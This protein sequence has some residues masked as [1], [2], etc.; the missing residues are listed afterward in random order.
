MRLTPCN[1][2]ARASARF[3][4]RDTVVQRIRSR[5]VVRTL[6]RRE[7]RA[8]LARNAAAGICRHGVGGL[9]LLALLATVHPEFHA[10][11]LLDRDALAAGEGWRLWTSHLAHFS[12]EHLLVD[13]LIFALLA[14]ALRRAGGRLIGRGLLIGGAVLSV[15]LLLCDSSLARYG[16]LSGFNALL[17]GWLAVRWLRAGG[18]Q[19]MFGALLLA[20]AIGKFAFDSVGLS[21]PSVAFDFDVV[22]SHLSHW[23]GVF[24]GVV[25]ACADQL[26]NTFSA[27]RRSIQSRSVAERKSRRSRMRATESA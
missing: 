17:L 3:R 15:S 21:A 19:Q 10:W 11:C 27:V 14:A 12:L 9:V 22:P 18:R 13:A 20:G 2:G 24:W 1:D 8:P 23:L 5:L 26:K 7:R 6:K 25:L 4:V 16:G